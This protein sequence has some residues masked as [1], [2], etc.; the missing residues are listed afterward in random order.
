MRVFKR[1]LLLLDSIDI[2]VSLSC[3]ISQSLIEDLIALLNTQTSTMRLLV[4]CMLRV[5]NIEKH[6]QMFG[7]YPLIFLIAVSYIIFWMG[8]VALLRFFR[9]S[10]NPN[11]IGFLGSWESLEIGHKLTSIGAKVLFLL[12]CSCFGCRYIEVQITKSSVQFVNYDIV[13]TYN[14]N[15][16]ISTEY[17]V[18]RKRVS[19]VSDALECRSESQYIFSFL[20]GVGF[21]IYTLIWLQFR[22]LQ[23]FRVNKR[24]FLFQNTNIWIAVYL[25]MTGIALTNHFGRRAFKVLSS[26]VQEI[27]Y[28]ETLAILGVYLLISV[29]PID[30]NRIVAKRLRIEIFLLLMLYIWICY[31]LYFKDERV[32]FA[33]A[34]IIIYLLFSTLAL[35]I[36]L[37]T[38]QLISDRRTRKMINYDD[39]E[40]REALIFIYF[41][42]IQYINSQK[43][44]V[45]EQQLMIKLEKYKV[46]W[47]KVFSRE[48]NGDPM[49]LSEKI[50]VDKQIMKLVLSNVGR[51]LKDYV[52]KNPEDKTIKYLELSF[53]IEIKYGFCK[54]VEILSKMPHSNSILGK[55]SNL[56]VTLLHF[57]LTEI[58]I[59]NQSHSFIKSIA[60]PPD[61]KCRETIERN[62]SY[63]RILNFLSEF[64]TTKTHMN[65]YIGA[66]LSL[67]FEIKSK[68]RM[69]NIH[70]QIDAAFSSKI[71]TISYFKRLSAYNAVRYTPLIYLQYI[72]EAEVKHAYKAAL[73]LCERLHHLDW[74]ENIY[75]L[76]NSKIVD[77]MIIIAVDGE[78]KNFHKIVSVFGNVHILG[79]KK[80][81]LL[82]MD[83][84]TIIPNAFSQFHENFLKL[85]DPIGGLLQ[86][87]GNYQTFIK[88]KNG[89]VT[90]IQLTIRLDY[91][92]NTGLRFIGFVDVNYDPDKIELVGILD[93]HG[94]VEDC[95][96]GL[97][98]FLKEG[99]STEVI[100]PQIT[101]DIEIMRRGLIIFNNHTFDQIAINSDY[102]DYLR[103]FFEWREGKIIDFVGEN[104]KVVV[105]I[106]EYLF[107]GINIKWVISVQDL[108]NEVRMVGEWKLWKRDFLFGENL[109][110]TKTLIKSISPSILKNGQ[111]NCRSSFFYEPEEKMLEAS[112]LVSNELIQDSVNLDVE[113]D[114]LLP[115]RNNLTRT[116]LKSQRNSTDKDKYVCSSE[117]ESEELFNLTKRENGLK[118]AKETEL[119]DI[120][121]PSQQLLKTKINRQR[122]EILNSKSNGL[123]VVIFC[124]FCIFVVVVYLL[125]RYRQSNVTESNLEIKEQLQTSDKFSWAIQS[126]PVNVFFLEMCRVVKSNIFSDDFLLLQGLASMIESCQNNLTTYGAFQLNI[127]L[128]I[129]DSMSKL[130]FPHL[131][132]FEWNNL[133]IELLDYSYSEDKTMR[134]RNITYSRNSAVTSVDGFNQHF[135]AR[136]YQDDLSIPILTG[137]DEEAR[138]EDPIEE[139]YRF[140]LQNNLYQE[141]VH[142]SY[143]FYEYLKNVALYGKT[144]ILIETMGCILI[145]V[146]FSILIGVVFMIE[147]CK[148]AEFF[149]NAFSLKVL[150]SIN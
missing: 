107:R 9:G 117:V 80:S 1:V 85:I 82:G 144:T 103:V 145:I 11:R 112:L 128:M 43:E 110:K 51:L 70:T 36:H 91:S 121:L 108:Q 68:G 59:I 86:H 77:Q 15:E 8:I 40:S 27:F 142:R 106:N 34:S 32:R 62:Q 16:V 148:I 67:L 131:V 111:I 83:L 118:N 29:S 100:N 52:S 66:Q 71:L 113:D 42:A 2:F 150:F 134:W 116:I 109:T 97:R 54:A 132:N 140:N 30:Y 39:R 94:N 138:R 7:Y 13:D 33:A 47:M 24:R 12:F 28:I 79:Y 135:I 72:F 23:I 26:S 44:L 130:R 136:N 102:R 61:Y 119:T 87:T 25:I 98:L 75:L 122:R 64:D 14:G 21:V 81:A 6:V 50:V 125:Q 139:L 53:L 56:F 49:K 19:Q 129:S 90:T 38:E 104:F 133:E 74:N 20:I 37:I 4:E 46:F 143:D 5:F 55:I 123:K 31:F 57:K 10:V 124:H 149:Y 114:C 137:Q 48:I 65:S 89:D 63:I 126:M 45:A 18:I 22:R 3:L 120:I 69:G 115:T 95:S 99:R 105:K 73:K 92:F 146:G 41:E 35:K 88:L 101:K 84:S 127:D 141:Y 96:S 78:K 147:V 17:L 76:N 93:E 58:G 60:S